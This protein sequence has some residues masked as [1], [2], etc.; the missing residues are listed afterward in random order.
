MQIVVSVTGSTNLAFSSMNYNVNIDETE[1]VGKSV[2][3]TKA[4]PE[5][6]NQL[7]IILAISLLMQTLLTN[8]SGL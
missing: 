5:V 6:S 7:L 4:L 8:Q 3:Q 1:P 2:I